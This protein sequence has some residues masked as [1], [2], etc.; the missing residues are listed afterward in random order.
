MSALRASGLDIDAQSGG[1]PAVVPD[2]PGDAPGIRDAQAVANAIALDETEAARARERF[3][4]DPIRPLEPDATIRPL[5]DPRGEN[6]FSI[7]RGAIINPPLG[8]G[9][10]LPGYAGT[11]YV[12]SHRLI[13]VGQVTMTI[14]LSNV[15]DI[16][17]AGEQL[18]LALRMGEGVSLRVDR[19]RLLRVEIAAARRAAAQPG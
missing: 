11:L 3:L 4:S 10:E 15:D 14:Q 2:R 19:P 18:L 7:R 9:H 5:L 17:L 16:S 13:H 1:H 6:V 12:T 8:G